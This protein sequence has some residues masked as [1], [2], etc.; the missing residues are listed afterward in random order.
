VPNLSDKVDIKLGLNGQVQ[1][2]NA[3]LAVQIAKYWIEKKST[4][5]SSYIRKCIYLNELNLKEIH[6]LIDTS[7]LN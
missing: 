6:L 1:Y 7:G 3:S 2:L 5:R 4:L